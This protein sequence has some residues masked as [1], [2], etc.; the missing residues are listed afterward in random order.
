[1]KGMHKIGNCPA[2]FIPRIRDKANTKRSR[3]SELEN[4]TV[5]AAAMKVK[6]IVKI[7]LAA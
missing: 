7:Y 1:M 6:N 4:L 5:I 3:E 2:I